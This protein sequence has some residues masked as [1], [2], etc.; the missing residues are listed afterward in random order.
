MKA[1]LAAAE[2]TQR[3]ASA[4]V[5]V[6]N[7]GPPPVYAAP[8]YVYPHVTTERYCGPISWIIG[9]LVLPCICFCPVDERQVHATVPMVAAP[10][11]V[12]Y[13]APPMQQ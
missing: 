7:S 9:L 13:P 11:G 4:P 5:V 10:S 6:N 2:A 8:T 12:V 1:R 3:S